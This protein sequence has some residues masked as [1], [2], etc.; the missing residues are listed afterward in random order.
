MKS[1]SFFQ[2]EIAQKILALP[3]SNPEGSGLTFMDR[4]GQA[5]RV[6]KRR[7]KRYCHRNSYTDTFFTMVW[8]DIKDYAVLLE[9]SK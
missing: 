3:K 7:V 9:K 5:I 6:L 8:Q 2:E 4:S 1:L